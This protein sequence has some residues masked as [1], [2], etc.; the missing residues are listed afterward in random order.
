MASYQY[1][2]LDLGI[3]ASNIIIG[4]DSAGGGLCMSLMLYLRDSNLPMV[5]SALL[6]CPWVDLTS[7]LNSWIEN[8]EVDYLPSRNFDE[9]EVGADSLPA[10]YVGQDN[11]EEKLHDPMVSSCLA[12]LQGL[13]PLLIQ[14][15]SREMLRDE[16]TLLAQRAARAGVKV[17]HELLVGGI[18]V[19]HS[20][21]TAPIAH[22]AFVNIGEWARALST[23]E[24]PLPASFLSNLR[25]LVQ[26]DLEAFQRRISRRPKSTPSTPKAQGAWRVVPSKAQ[27]PKAVGRGDGG[28]H[29]EVQ[30]ALEENDRYEHPDAVFWTPVKGESAGL[31][32]RLRTAVGM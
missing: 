4:G 21:R 30:R 9:D 17:S 26:P 25:T 27:P 22:Q 15:G 7:S 23:P 20:F 19:P 14:S 18:H 13:P 1:L 3:P 12:D 10:L 29:P 8:G 6:I 5:H 32:S 31:V 16:H 11:F 28:L 24:Q 2:T